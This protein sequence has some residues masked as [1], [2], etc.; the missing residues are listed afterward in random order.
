MANNCVDSDTGA[1]NHDVYRRFADRPLEPLRGGS[2]RGKQPAR[3]LDRD[4]VRV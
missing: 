2:P 1:H 3:D 4:S